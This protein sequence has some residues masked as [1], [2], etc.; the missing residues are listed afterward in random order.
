[1]NQSNT[2]NIACQIANLFGG[3]IIET[4]N[5]NDQSFLNLDAFGKQWG[6]KRSGNIKDWSKLVIKQA[7]NE[8]I[9]CVFDWCKPIKGTILEHLL[10]MTI[11][12][13]SWSLEVKNEFIMRIDAAIEPIKIIKSTSCHFLSKISLGFCNWI[14]SFSLSSSSEEP[15]IY[16][17]LTNSVFLSLFKISFELLDRPIAVS[18]THLTLPTIYSV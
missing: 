16:I 4:N 12:P 15:A 8:E 10:S 5:S 1:M 9:F 18:Y 17:S 6:W 3:E 7:K 14:S 13:G 2:K 11:T